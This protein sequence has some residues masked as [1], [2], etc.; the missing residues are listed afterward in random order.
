MRDEEERGQDGRTGEDVG[1]LEPKKKET[2][3]APVSC[4]LGGVEYNRKE[5]MW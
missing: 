3:L 5:K 4:G 2:D 1:Y